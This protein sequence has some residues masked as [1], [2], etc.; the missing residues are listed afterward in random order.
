MTAKHRGGGKV[1]TAAQTLPDVDFRH[2]DLPALDRPAPDLPAPDRPGSDARPPGAG[3]PRYAGSP[4]TASPSTASPS[5]GGPKYAGVPSH[6]GGPS[7]GQGPGGVRRSSDSPGRRVARGLGE[8]LLTCGVVLLLFLGYEV[9]VSNLF[10]ERK[11]AQVREQLITSWAR[12]QDPLKGQD[13]RNLPIAKQVAL[14]AGQGFANLYIP[15]LGKDYVRTVVQG[16]SDRH[17]ESGPGHYVNSQLPGQL[18]NFAVA[19]HRVSKGQPF[20][21]LDRLRPGDSIVVQTARNWYVYAVLGSRSA[22]LAANKLA[23][24]DKREAAVAAALAK[25]DSQGVRGREIVHPAAVHVIDPVPNHPRAVATRALLTL[26]TC[27]PK[28][29]ADQR[30]VVHAQLSRAVPRTGSLLPA[31]LPGGTI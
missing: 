3:G 10:A 9:W 12:G 27:H 28:Y 4:S 5:T 13:R 8:L 29:S 26:T 2:P 20:L 30:L 31:E 15:V 14:P 18:G 23:D 17:L 7:V 11:Q 6:V 25:P 24:P 19:G 16:T 1:A 21:N 22:Y